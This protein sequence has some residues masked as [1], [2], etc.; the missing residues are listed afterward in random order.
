[1]RAFAS[2]VKSATLGLRRMG[3][4]ALSDGHC[5]ACTYQT[6]PAAFARLGDVRYIRCPNTR[7]SN[8]VAAVVIGINN[9]ARRALVVVSSHRVP[10]VRSEPPVDKESESST[11]CGRC[12]L[13]TSGSLR[14]A[15][16]A[17]F[18]YVTVATSTTTTI[19]SAMSE[20]RRR[21]EFTGLP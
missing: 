11:P 2:N 5:R 10:D 20:K 8:S 21:T 13:R 19:A 18:E 6:G 17:K 9:V 3:P 15:D 4:S 7:A 1:M 14:D 16:E 12:P